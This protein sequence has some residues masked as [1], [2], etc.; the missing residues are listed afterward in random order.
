MTKDELK[1]FITAINSAKNSNILS[2]YFVKKPSSVKMQSF[3]PQISVQVQSDI[4]SMI[5]PNILRQLDNA[6][7][8]EYNPIGVADGEIEYLNKNSIEQIDTFLDSISDEKIYKEMKAL[9]IPKISFY[10]FKIQYNEKIIYC[11]RQF[12][13]MKKL[14]SGYI[15]QFFNDELKAMDGNFLGIDETV[16]M[17]YADDVAYIFNHISLERIFNYRDQYLQKTNEAMG[18]LLR[19]NA[20]AN[21]EQFSEDCCRDVRIMKRFTNM[22]TQGRLPL[23]FDNYEKVPEIVEELGLDI[24]FD[25]EGR[26]D[27]KEKSQLY[28]IVN[29][30]SDSYFESLLAKR[31]GI[32][33]TEEALS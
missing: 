10:C 15:A 18:E 32:V 1:S 27:Y 7:L 28:H 31:R 12:A 4:L 16:D 25:D 2:A 29:L 17:I 24:D 26:I 6:A 21:M 11:F 19:Q 9:E 22:M 23:F 3:Q 13:K 5:I 20:I 33:K 8:V 14:R 30:M